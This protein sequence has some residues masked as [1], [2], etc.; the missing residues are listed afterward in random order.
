MK[1]VWDACEINATIA[2][3]C[4]GL[5][6]PASLS[7]AAQWRTPSREEFLKE[8]NIQVAPAIGPRI[9]AALDKTEAGQ[10][11]EWLLLI[12]EMSIEE[13]A[14]HY[15]AF[16]QMQI[17]NLPGWVGSSEDTRAR[18]LEAASQ[19]L[20]QSN[21]PELESSASRQ[22]RNGSS[23]A[24]NALVLLHSTE[25]SYL[26]A[27]PG[28]FWIRWIPSVVEDGRAGHDKEPGIKAVFQFAA[29][30][31]PDAMNDRLLEQLRFENGSEQQYFFSST[32]VE[33]AWSESLG[34]LLLD[35]LRQ[36]N[37]VPSIQG[38]V[39]Y[40]LL[41]NDVPGARE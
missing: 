22:T 4:K 27:Q 25:P 39:L 16:Q 19:Y 9:E 24:V 12:N 13:G 33:Q 11:D 17:E 14:T 20:T 32:L 7:E 29:K 8:H 37:L 3:E 28:E 6:E 21:F 1:A 38:V 35:E 40:M 26:Q 10:A 5:F 31:A 2:G 41:N 18:I 36:N 23:A 34:I 15:V 30:S